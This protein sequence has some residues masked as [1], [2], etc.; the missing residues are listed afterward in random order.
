MSADHNLRIS[1]SQKT[2][3]RRFLK[4]KASSTSGY[5][6]DTVFKKK[7]KHHMEVFLTIK[8]LSTIEEIMQQDTEETCELCMSLDSILHKAYLS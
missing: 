6:S 2:T 4:P 5:I 7:K 1:E 8:F 3:A